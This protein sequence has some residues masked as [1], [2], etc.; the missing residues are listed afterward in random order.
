M[1]DLLACPN[2]A[3]DIFQGEFDWFVL[4]DFQEWGGDGRRIKRQQ[5]RQL[6]PKEYSYKNH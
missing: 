6:D 3:N 1:F 5:W 2:N 4:C